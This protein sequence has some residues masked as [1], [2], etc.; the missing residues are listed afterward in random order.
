M[1]VEGKGLLAMDES[2]PTG[3]K[4]FAAAGIPQSEEA[5][6]SY[7]ERIITTPGLGEFISGVILYDETI[8]QSKAD[9]KPP[10]NALG[11][12]FGARGIQRRALAEVRIRIP[13]RAPLPTEARLK[14][15]G[16]SG[17]SHGLGHGNFE[18]RN[19]S[20]STPAG[21]ASARTN[22]ASHWTKLRDRD[23]GQETNRATSGVRCHHAR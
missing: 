22:W 12:D 2:T 1:L 10:H 4:R 6:R 5:R 23:Q 3:N 13:I 9:G 16:P 15:W 20:V 8:R 21:A 18:D 19:S 14:R 11:S 17:E 7:R